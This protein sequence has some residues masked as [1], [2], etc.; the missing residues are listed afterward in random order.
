V[1]FCRE[2]REEA[3]MA[4]IRKARPNIHDQ[5]ADLKRQLSHVRPDEWA[6]IPEIGELNEFHSFF[7][8]AHL[9]LGFLKFCHCFDHDHFS[10]NLI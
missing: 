3:E 6:A 4:K 2:R 9:V 10:F 1:S 7:F 5:F 8:I